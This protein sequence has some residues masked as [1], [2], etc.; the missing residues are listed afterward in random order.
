VLVPCA[1]LLP[2]LAQDGCRLPELPERMGH[3]ALEPVEPQLRPLIRELLVEGADAIEDA[4]GILR[5]AGGGEEL[6]V[7]VLRAAEPIRS[8]A[9]PIAR[10]RSEFK[11]ARLLEYLGHYKEAVQLFEAVIA[12]AFDREA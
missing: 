7:G 6:R 9:S 11:A 12:D 2:H 8:G 5:P 1:E 4:E 3:P 10:R